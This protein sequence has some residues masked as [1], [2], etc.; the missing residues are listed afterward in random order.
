MS[1]F[2]SILYIAYI[3]FYIHLATFILSTFTIVGTGKLLF[4][5]NGNRHHHQYYFRPEENL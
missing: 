4:K 2:Y 5:S 3:C 1:I